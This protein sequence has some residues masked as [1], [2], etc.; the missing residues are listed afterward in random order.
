MHRPIGLRDDI[1]AVPFH[2]ESPEILLIVVFR[3]L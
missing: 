2:A 3:K 1:A